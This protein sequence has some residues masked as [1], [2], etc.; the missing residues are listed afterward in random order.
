MA[1]TTFTRLNSQ[2]KIKR[3][4]ELFLVPLGSMIR[5]SPRDEHSV[6][7]SERFSVQEDK[8]GI[9]IDSREIEGIEFANMDELIEKLSLIFIPVESS[10][11]VD[12]QSTRVKTAS[13]ASTTLQIALMG[14]VANLAVADFSL[15]DNALF[16]LKN[17]GPAQI[18]L[19]VK[20]ANSDAWILTKFDPGWNPEILKAIKINASAD[21]NLKYGY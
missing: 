19:E 15:P 17:D 16:M 3:G 12:G 1:V 9:V 8:D 10:M 2:V 21:I 11:A 7:I 18:E 14:I 20:L 13:G 6:I 4:D 5:T